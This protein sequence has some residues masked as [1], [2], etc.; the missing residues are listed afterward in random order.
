MLRQP[1]PAAAALTALL[2]TFSL[3]ACRGPS[4]APIGEAPSNASDVTA[5]LA[6][7]N[8]TLLRL[9]NAGNEAGWVQ[10]TYITPDTQAM[11]ARASEAYATA[12]TNFAKKAATLGDRGTADERRQLTCSRTR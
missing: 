3:S 7:A 6:D 1:Y 2:L 9:G 10:A 4:P 12:A 11:A 8:E 5:F